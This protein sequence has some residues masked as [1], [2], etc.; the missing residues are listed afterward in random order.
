[1]YADPSKIRNV[2]LRVRLTEEED[3]LLNAVVAYT[4]QQKSSLMRDL[5]IDQATRVLSGQGDVGTGTF[6]NEVPQQA[7]NFSR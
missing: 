7:M 1:M 6:G 3:N 5:F 2:V 4:G